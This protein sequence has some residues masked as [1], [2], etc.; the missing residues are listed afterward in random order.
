MSYILDA[1]R[2]SEQERNQGEVPNLETVQTS[3]F[4]ERQSKSRNLTWLYVLLGANVLVA[5]FWLGIKFTEWR[6]P[7]TGSETAVSESAPA[8]HD[9]ANESK[10]ADAER[11]E[12][13]PVDHHSQPE[14]PVATQTE[15]A[16]PRTVND[17]VEQV[18]SAAPSTESAEEEGYTLVEPSQRASRTV[19]RAEQ[20]YATLPS[21]YDLRPGLQRQIS[22]LE[23]SS[24]MYSSD[25][26]FR[27]VVINGDYLKEGERLEGDL[28]LEA[29]TEEGVIMTISGERFRVSVMQDWSFQ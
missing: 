13:S 1:L 14:S 18:S 6:M 15:S 22:V 10:P 28:M 21:I 5:I 27:S 2:K 20:D 7:T 26:D 19:A 8:Q 12:A 16:A 24:H 23:F 29:I 11:V 3:L 17:E 4:Q 25:P 9:A